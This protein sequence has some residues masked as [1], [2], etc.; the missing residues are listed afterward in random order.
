MMNLDQALVNMASAPPVVASARAPQVLLAG[1][2]GALGRALMARLALSSVSSVLHIAGL[3]AHVSSSARVKAWLVTP[4][5]PTA[6]WGTSRVVPDVAV[7]ALGLPAVRAT[8][9]V[10][11]Q[12]KPSELLPFVQHL[13]LLGTR[14]LVLVMPHEPGKLPNAL[15]HGLAS[16]DEQ[17]IAALGFD[18]LLIVRSPQ[19]PADL[20]AANWG[21]KLAR[22][23]LS[24]S[25]YLI[26][27]ADQPVRA[28]GFAEFVAE[29]IK[30][31][32]AL[33]IEGAQV[34]P[35]ETVWQAL[36]P[37]T[38]E[39]GQQ[40]I[41]VAAAAITSLARSVTSPRNPSNS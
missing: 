27:A 8:E 13:Y 29:L 1:A 32:W 21:E 3:A 38:H 33:Q 28:D 7:I 9:Q 16:L 26:P 12:P 2:G 5:V 10:W 25:S 20:A 31:S 34:V 17:A 24:I 40:R 14:R 36:Q 18:H 41:D 37:R 23:M 19:R 11:W 6:P 15:K 30:A 22:L 35:P 39:D 4:G